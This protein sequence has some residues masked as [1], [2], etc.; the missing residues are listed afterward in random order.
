M[1][2]QIVYAGA[3]PLDTDQLLQSRATMVAI[4]Y[5]AK[6]VLG[7][8]GPVVDG[9]SCLPA[10]G[11]SVQIGAG[12]FAEPWIVDSSP[13][14]S[15]PPD[16]D[17]LVKIGINSSPTFLSV[18]GAGQWSVF[19]TLVEAQAGSASISYYNAANPLQT[20]IG[21]QGNGQPQA[22]VVQQRVGLQIG[23]A[24]AAPAGAI[25]LWSITVPAGAA[26]IDGSMISPVPQA[27]FIAVKLPFAAPL[28]SPAFNGVPTAPTASPGDASATLATTGFVAAANARNRAAW[29]ASGTHS[30]VCPPGVSTILARLWAAGGQGGS[31]ASGYA[32]GGGGGGG[33]EE[34]LL[35][36]TA[37]T[38]YSIQVGS[39]SGGSSASS[40]D[41]LAS[42]SGGVAGGTANANGPGSGGAA[43]SSS[44]TGF[45]IVAA[46]GV[47][48]GTSGFQI[49]STS[50]GG[51]GGPSFGVAGG[52]A[53]FGRAIGF[54]GVWPG[55]GGGGGSVGAGGKGADGL[56]VIEW[57][58]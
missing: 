36:V 20:L 46:L 58:G 9:L 40:F 34:V 31:A 43:G 37:G 35:S 41:I 49:G 42:V 11:L 45:N 39:G 7:D 26:S 2:R 21:A 6:M 19:A 3:I 5:L 27:P 25:P 53:A 22:T 50:V 29:G 16:G 47:A 17:P 1:D 12:C 33:Y 51:A 23:A 18:P 52:Q 28:A 48:S 30:W 15:L 10:A 38:T 4:G 14:G 54:D 56:V 32:G 55:G 24:N 13:Y 44:S 57:N 8:G